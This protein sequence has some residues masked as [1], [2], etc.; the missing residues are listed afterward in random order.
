MS[1]QLKKSNYDN[2]G[3]AVV[4]LD[5]KTYDP[6]PKHLRATLL[7]YELQPRINP[8]LTNSLTVG[9]RLA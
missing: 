2:W 7:G 1:P 8:L 6:R 9:F 4:N 5:W 3:V